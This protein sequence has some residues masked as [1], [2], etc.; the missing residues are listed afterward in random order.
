MTVVTP[1]GEKNFQITE[2][3]YIQFLLTLF[4]DLSTIFLS[5]TKLFSIHFSLRNFSFFPSFSPDSYP[6]SFKQFPEI[7]NSGTWQILVYFINFSNSESS[8]LFSKHAEKSNKATQFVTIIF[9]DTPY[10]VPIYKNR[11]PTDVNQR[12]D[13]FQFFPDFCEY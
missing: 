11:L 1:S 12:S 6:C 13:H 2:V 5:K 3:K 8:I 4:K 7:G 9:Q 10:A